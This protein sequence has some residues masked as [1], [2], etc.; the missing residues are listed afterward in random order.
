MDTDL[1]ARETLP[2]LIRRSLAQPR[3]VAL[4][5]RQGPS[6]VTV[7]A[8]QLL[9]RAQNVAWA[10]LD[11][12]LQPG[13]RVALI[14][15]NRI[16]WIVA[17]FGILLSGC[18]VVPIFAT[19]ALDQVA[20]ILKDSEAK[21][22]FVDSPNA[23]GRLRRIDAP[24]P[25]AV[26]FDAP[27][28]DG[29][30]A[31]ESFGAAARRADPALLSRIESQLRP[32]DLAILIYTSGTTGVPKGV[33]LS[34]YNLVFTAGS[35]FAYA[36][37]LVKA[38]EPVLSVLPFSHIY[39]HEILYGYMLSG[40]AHYICRTPDD[41]AR[42]LKDIRPVAMTVVPRIFERMLAAIAGA[43]MKQGGLR[44]RLV[45]WALATGRRYATKRT[46]KLRTSLALWIQ[47]RLARALVLRKI[48]RLLG[49]DRLRFFVSG[50]ARLHFDTAMTLDACDLTII[51]GYGPTECSP[52]ITVNRPDTN[53]YGTVGRPIPGVQI[54]LAP[55]GEVLASG[56]NVMRG[57]YR[58][59]AGTDA[60]MQD[61]WYATGDIG[62]IDADGYLSITDRKKELFKT[63]GGK[64]VSPARVESAIKRS[65]FVSQVMLVG[66]GRPYPV[67][68]VSP[69]WDV[70]RSR[71]GIAEDV[72][73]ER[74]A[75]RSDVV[76]FIEDEVRG[77][78]G[79][80]ATFEQVRRVVVLPHELS[81]EDGDLSPTL[82][83][84][85][86]I[87]EGK[88]A[89]AIASLYESSSRQ[90]MHVEI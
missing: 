40:A 64:F 60:V 23:L 67:A 85:R 19:Q 39:E 34:H 86:R 6:W 79:D 38:L 46:R 1:P 73:T 78:T 45:P 31:F 42:D 87:V 43:A 5:E 35:S 10:L 52:V 20:Y 74:L 29:L 16:D 66:E 51:E 56:P 27:G 17:D 12:G 62:D 59:A 69:N 33:M 47:H 15:L 81:I 90:S 75:S 70:L 57:Y 14:S 24:L 88:Y 4:G 21:L 41:L 44:A 68:L 76:S 2:A 28:G 3:D 65:I 18:V 72:P 80:L 89:A 13:D 58:D 30:R 61:G 8:S 55:D 54:R 25:R 7:S 53:R 82:K 9:E 50:S 32:D 37:Y 48:P 63:S 22:V 84:R 49:L 11:A 77:Q 83:V 71:C 26:V 36:F